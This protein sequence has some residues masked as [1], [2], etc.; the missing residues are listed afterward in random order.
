MAGNVVEVDQQSWNAEVV[1]SDKPVLVDFWAAW[2]GPCRMVAPTIEELA[3]EYS[4]KIK[5]VKLNVDDNPAIAGQYQVMS[6][7]TFAVLVNGAVKKRF[8]G[9]MPKDGFVAELKEWLG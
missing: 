8:V 9:A 6:I 5:F 1:N 3:N 7:P 4:D 2:C